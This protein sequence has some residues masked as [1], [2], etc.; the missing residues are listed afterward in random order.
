MLARVAPDG[1]Y[2]SVSTATRRVH[3]LG[4]TRYPEEVWTA[5]QA[6]NP[7][8][9]LACAHLPCQSERCA[10]R[11]LHPAV[12]ARTSFPFAALTWQYYGS[13]LVAGPGFEPG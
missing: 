1:T 6:R 4:V 13:S 2:T 12:R 9:D 7:V 8:M 3:I 10:D 11:S 5:Q